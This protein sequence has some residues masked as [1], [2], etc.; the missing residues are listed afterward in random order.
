[1]KEIKVFNFFR[2]RTHLTPEN[3]D[4]HRKI[5]SLTEENFIK[6]IIFLLKNNTWKFHTDNYLYI[7]VGKMKISFYDYRDFS[8]TILS[9][10]VNNKFINLFDSTIY[11]NKDLK[12][13]NDLAVE[14]LEDLK[15]KYID[16]EIKKKVLKANKPR[17]DI[18]Q[19][20]IDAVNK[21]KSE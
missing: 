15:L 18:M 20:V 16:F 12:E 11:P 8:N 6:Q 14:K 2:K 5:H 1:M 10:K 17:V 21:I 7:K 4:M 13:M 19:K 9:I 3:I